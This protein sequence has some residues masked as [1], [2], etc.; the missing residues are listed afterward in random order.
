MQWEVC[1]EGCDNDG[2]TFGKKRSI[3]IKSI[4]IIKKNIQWECRWIATTMAKEWSIIGIEKKNVLL[5][6]HACKC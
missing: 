5:E 2:E 1:S 3:R 4:E 6:Q